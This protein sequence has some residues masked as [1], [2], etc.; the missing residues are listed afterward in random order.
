[1][2]QD[3]EVSGGTWDWEKMR[4]RERER[5]NKKGNKT[6]KIAPSDKNRT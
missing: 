1:M 2:M 6:L 4:E 3:N 5:E